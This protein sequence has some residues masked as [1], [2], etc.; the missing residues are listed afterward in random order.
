VG[1]EKLPIL[2]GELGSFSKDKT[3]WQQINEH[4]RLYAASDSNSSII[5]TKDLNHKGD[6]IHFNAEG[7]RLLGERF[8]REY[9][10]LSKK[11]L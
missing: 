10:K 2:I 9:L 5:K 6:S 3:Y 8:A 7:Q 11:P 1:D 4:I